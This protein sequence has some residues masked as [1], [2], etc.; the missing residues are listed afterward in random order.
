MIYEP[1][2]QVSEIFG[3]TFQG[4]GPSV[5]RR[6]AF[7][8]LGG[9]GLHC[10]WCDTPYTWRYSEAH[11]H[12]GNVIY[13]PRKE[14]K[15][16]SAVEINNQLRQIPVDMLVV[17]GG[18]PMLQQ[19]KLMRLLPE[20]MR[21]SWRVEVETAGV[22]FPTDNFIKYV[23][24]FNVSPKL[25]HS[26]NSVEIRYKPDILRRFQA[27][28]GCIFKFVV[29][30]ISDLKEVDA[31]VQECGLTN[32]WIMPEGIDSKTLLERATLLADEVS[33]RGYNMTNRL[34]IL[35]WGSKRGV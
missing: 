29:Q 25:E 13:D 16:L 12:E 14:I 33:K 1:L 28:S 17:S 6:C 27:Q 10:S 26:G 24:Q 21:W 34:H 35:T 5:G 4:E 31:I 19:G 9:C 3:P 2:L 23:N 8:R 7:L 11:P 18:E 20:V 15:Q 30:Q 32:V 22:I